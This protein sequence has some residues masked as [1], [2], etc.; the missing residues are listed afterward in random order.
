MSENLTSLSTTVNFSDTWLLNLDDNLF[1]PY[2]EFKLIIYSS[3]QLYAHDLDVKC[4]WVNA[5]GKSSKHANGRETNNLKFWKVNQTL[6]QK[7]HWDVS[8]RPETQSKRV[9]HESV[10]QIYSVIPWETYY[11]MNNLVILSWENQ[12]RDISQT[13]TLYW[14]D[15]RNN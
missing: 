7:V 8:L 2:S 1:V 11:E 12:E 5:P 15:W 4:R 9:L 14:Q 3:I 13:G 6:S 10:S